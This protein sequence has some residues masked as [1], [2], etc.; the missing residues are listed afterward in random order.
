LSLLSAIASGAVAQ[1]TNRAWGAVP[2]APVVDQSG[3]VLPGVTVTVNLGQTGAGDSVVSDAEGT[4]AVTQISPPLR[5]CV[6]PERG[7]TQEILR[8]RWGGKHRDVDTQLTIAGASEM[9][10]SGANPGPGPELGAD[11]GVN[12]SPVEVESLPVNGRNFAPD[13]AGHRQRPP[14]ATAAGAASASTANPTSRTT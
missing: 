2:R 5:D 14:T 4:Y 13:D 7:S 12:V 10:P 8:S 3:A 11:G 9:S 1:Q 6:R